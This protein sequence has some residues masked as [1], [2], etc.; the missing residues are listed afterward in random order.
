MNLLYSIILGIIQGLTEFLPVSSSG[1]LVLAEEF[2]N[3]HQD[4]SFEIILHFGSLMA[5]LIYFRKDI[6]SLAE[7]TFK[8]NNKEIK[9]SENRKI[10]LYLL[11]ATFI[12]GVI[13]ILFK[14]YLE[15]LFSKP[16]FAAILLSV[17]AIILFTSDKINTKNISTDKMGFT[18]AIL[19]GLGQSFAL[20]PGISRSGSTIAMS[21]FCGLKREQ[22][23]KFSFLL[24]IPAIF[25]ALVL[26][27]KEILALDSSLLISY[28][29]GAFAAFISGYLVIKLL[30]RLVQKQKLKYFAYYCWS[31]SLISIILLFIGKI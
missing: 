12:T 18:R 16:I 26:K 17:T 27:Y 11:V 19:I 22:V 2:L 5:V 29:A 23:A 30:L 6:F 24:S 8:F 3:F 31:V 20:L 21:I 9:H 14:D 15:E 13:G 1:H 28:L 10:V 4:L 25:G 7:S